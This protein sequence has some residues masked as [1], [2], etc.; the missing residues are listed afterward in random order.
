MYHTVP[1]EAADKSEEWARI[2]VVNDVK[3]VE[4]VFAKDIQEL[5]HHL[6]EDDKKEAK[7]EAKLETETKLFK[8]Q[9]KAVWY[10]KQYEKERK[11]NEE[12]RDH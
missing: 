3:K 5:K 7:L 11:S 10:E 8:A 2:K 12:A 1:A 9:A 4:E 6:A